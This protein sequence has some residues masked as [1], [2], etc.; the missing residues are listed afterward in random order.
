MCGWVRGV[1]RMRRCSQLQTVCGWF[2]IQSLIGN[3]S[4]NL[5]SVHNKVISKIVCV[6]GRCYLG[7]WGQRSKVLAVCTWF[8]FF[9]YCTEWQC[10]CVWLGGAGY[11]WFMIGVRRSEA[12]PRAEAVEL[13]AVAP[14]VVPLLHPLAISCRCSVWA[15]FPFGRKEPFPLR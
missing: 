3:I 14:T 2:C 8:V 11:A 6:W 15:R 7:Q 13:L 12:G 1:N 10:G 9:L 4:I 5:Y